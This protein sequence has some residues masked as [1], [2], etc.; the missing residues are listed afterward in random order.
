M[1]ALDEVLLSLT[2][3]EAEWAYLLGPEEFWMWW[4]RR[5]QEEEK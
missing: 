3:E 5:E 4:D 2:E 1:M